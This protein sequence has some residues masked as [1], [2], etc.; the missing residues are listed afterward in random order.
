MHDDKIPSTL[1]SHANQGISSIINEFPCKNCCT[2]RIRRKISD[3]ILSP[4][5]FDG[6]I[7]ETL[8]ERFTFEF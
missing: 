5:F 4:E 6:G 7:K 2:K 1:A 3:A 8:F